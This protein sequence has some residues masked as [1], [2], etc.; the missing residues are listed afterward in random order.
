MKFEWLLDELKGNHLLCLKS[1]S[2]LFFR[3]TLSRED[4][5]RR[6]WQSFP[7][8]EPTEVS[9][10]L[11]IARRQCEEFVRKLTVLQLYGGQNDNGKESILNR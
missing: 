1:E 8:R 5:G 6:I 2:A 4:S 9:G 3:G 7:E 10:D 11:E